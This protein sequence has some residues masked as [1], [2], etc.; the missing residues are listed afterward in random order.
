M[1]NLPPHRTSR[2]LRNKPASHRDPLGI[3]TFSGHRGIAVRQPVQ[4]GTYFGR[5]LDAGHG[6][7][8]WYDLHKFSIRDI[9]HGAPLGVTW[10]SPMD[11]RPEV[12]CELSRDSRFGQR[13][14]HSLA[15]EIGDRLTDSLVECGGVGEGLMGE[16]K[17]L[18]IVPDDL[19]GV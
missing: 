15:V 11:A 19:D 10:A 6:P 3:L 1:E 4:R 2:D 8:I 18:K 16:V 5:R 17:C 14:A 9:G 13:I 7:K 12:G